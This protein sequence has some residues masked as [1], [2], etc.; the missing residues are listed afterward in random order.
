MNF[1]PYLKEM[2]SE[3]KQD[4]ELI[5]MGTKDQKYV[6]GVAAKLQKEE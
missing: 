3:L 2:L 5:L 1:R 4:F 6:E